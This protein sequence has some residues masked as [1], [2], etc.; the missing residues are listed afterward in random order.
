MT[1]LIADCL[2]YL[3]SQCC[4]VTVNYV[5][6]ISCVFRLCSEYATIVTREL[7]SSLC[8][9]PFFFSSYGWASSITGQKLSV[10]VSV[11]V[12]SHVFYA[13]EFMEARKTCYWV[14]R[15]SIWSNP[16]SKELCNK[17]VVQTSETLI[18]I[19][20]HLVLFTLLGPI[21]QMQLKWCQTDC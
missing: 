6:I 17:N 8:V 5:V 15:T 7:V 21:S 10:C 14:V 1:L 4:V 12:A 19:T 3:V 9:L 20:P 2:I 11:W 13:M 16:Y 18:V